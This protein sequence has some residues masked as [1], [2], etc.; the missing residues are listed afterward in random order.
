[1]STTGTGVSIIDIVTIIMAGISLVISIVVAVIQFFQQRSIHRASLNSKYHDEIFLDH[2]IHKIP[3][4][5]K[6]IRFNEAGK[7]DD[8][9]KLTDELSQMLNGALYYKYKDNGFYKKLKDKIQDIEDYVMNCGNKS[10]EQEEQ[11]EVYKKIQEK[12][13]KMYKLI[14]DQYLGR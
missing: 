11:A 4:A 12:L 3:E 6:Y 13:E 9:E 5:R 7:L 8:I 14:N 1:M 10:F 2:L